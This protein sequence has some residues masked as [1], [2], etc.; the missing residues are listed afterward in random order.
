MCC[1]EHS[2][3]SQYVRRGE[4]HNS[5]FLITTVAKL[6]S[7]IVT[8]FRKFKHFVIDKPK[9]GKILFL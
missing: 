5:C 7:G 1:T 4:I 8:T 6:N 2:D 3:R 9:V